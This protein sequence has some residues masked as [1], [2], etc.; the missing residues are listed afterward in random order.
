MS[1]LDLLVQNIIGIRVK[2]KEKSKHRMASHRYY[3]SSFALLPFL[4]AYSWEGLRL[5]AYGFPFT[6]L[7]IYIFL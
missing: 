1:A 5:T 2:H 3:M 4:L 6:L 7:S